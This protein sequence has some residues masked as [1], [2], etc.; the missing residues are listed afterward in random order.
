[1]DLQNS[2]AFSIGSAPLNVVLINPPPL[3]IVEPWY[4]RPNWGRIA[5]AYL[6][7]YLRQLRGVDVTI[8][9]AK[10]EGLDFRQ[11]LDQVASL[12]PHVV[13]L[14]LPTRSNRPHTRPH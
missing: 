3:A 11:T 4:D 12:Q 1:M 14:P 2:P 13:G 10:L 8:V 5:L 7:S 6:A 9:D